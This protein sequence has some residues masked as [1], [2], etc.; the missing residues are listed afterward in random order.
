MCNLVL[1][2]P[3]IDTYETWDSNEGTSTDNV[4]WMN[5]DIDF[6]V[7]DITDYDADF[8]CFDWDD[9]ET[10]DNCYYDSNGCGGS[11]TTESCNYYAIPNSMNDNNKESCDVEGNCRE[12]T[13]VD[14]QVCDGCDFDTSDIQS[15]YVDAVV[16]YDC[17]DSQSNRHVDSLDEVHF[18]VVYP[19]KYDCDSDAGESGDD[20][21]GTGYYDFEG[22]FGT[23]WVNI[24]SDVTCPSYRVC[25]PDSSHTYHDDQEVTSRTG[26]ITH[27]CTLEDGST[28][29]HECSSDDDCYSDDCDG[30]QTVYEPTCEGSCSDGYNLNVDQYSDTC[31]G[32]GYKY[33]SADDDFTC[34]QYLGSAYVCDADL[35]GGNTNDPADFCR[36]YQD[37]SCSQSTECCGYYNGYACNDGYCS[38]CG[39]YYCN[40][41]E[42]ASDC[43]QDCCDYECSD[44]LAIEGPG[45]GSGKCFSECDGYNGCVFYNSATRNACD[46]EDKDEVVCVDEDTYVTCCE[47]TPSDCASYKYCYSGSCLTCNT[48]CNDNCQSSACYGDDPDCDSDGN[49]NGNCGDGVCCQ[50]T[51][52]SCPQDCGGVSYCNGTIEI[53]TE[54]S[55]GNPQGNLSIYI[56]S[57]Y[58]SSTDIYGDK[59]VPIKNVACGTDYNITVKCENNDIC[60][61]KIASIDESDDG[62]DLDPL[63]FDCTIC[64]GEEDIYITKDDIR[65]RSQNGQANITATVNVENVE[66]SNLKVNFTVVNKDG[67]LGD[68]QAYTI[69]SFNKYTK[70]KA[71]VLLDFSSNS[72]TVNIYVDPENDFTQDS[73]TN[74]FVSV[75]AIILETKAYLDIET[76]YPVVDDEI[77]DYLD[78]YVDSVSSDEAEVKIYVSI[79]NSNLNLPSLSGNKWRIDTLSRAVIVND[80]TGNKPY[81]GFVASFEDGS[82]NVIYV[83]GTDIEGVIASIK[84]LVDER[85]RFLV[86]S[87][88]GRDDKIYLGELDLEAIRVYDYMHNTENDATSNYNRYSTDFRNIVKNALEKQNYDT[89]IKLVRTTNADNVTLRIRHLSP[90]L[91]P[92]LR[93]AT[94][95][96]DQPVVLAHGIHSSLDSWKDFGIELAQNGRDPWLIEPYGGPGTD[97]E[98]GDNCPDYDFSDLKT[99]YWPALIAGVQTYSGKNNLSYVGYD[100]GC[101]VGLES[102]ELYPSG[103]TDIGYYL[104]SDEW[105]LTD[106]SDDPIDTFVGVA[107]IGNFSPIVVNSTFS[108]YPVFTQYLKDYQSYYQDDS[109]TF[110]QYGGH[111]PGGYYNSRGW[112][113]SFLP[114]PPIQWYYSVIGSLILSSLDVNTPSLSSSKISMGVYQDIISWINDSDNP[115]IGQNVQL[116]N[117]AIMQSSFD[118]D[119]EYGAGYGVREYRKGTDLFV[120]N[121]TQKAVCKNIVSDNKYYIGFKNFAHFGPNLPQ[122]IFIGTFP[123]SKELRNTIIYFLNNKE[124]GEGD[125]DIISTSSNCE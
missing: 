63:L 15:T 124:I 114:T 52:V 32:S 65:I 123:A 38:K 17:D 57:E 101:T 85:N 24:K 91:T 56:D 16:Y 19:K 82:D 8:V 18:W 11:C 98:C 74:N 95:D 20:K 2:V 7:N 107:C 120:S 81:N 4:I 34:S 87:N 118:M 102:L 46:G 5:D 84:R 67:S 103:Q 23:S 31:G 122:P 28:S 125:Y 77:R 80:K 49:V 86:S 113:M 64:K 69:T 93:G 27:P 106:L 45:G 100:L 89:S 88:L 48:Q 29:N 22:D 53:I 13:N 26:S 43:P 121:Q 108:I 47:G 21:S 12:G 115:K 83:I 75:P 55:E 35:D 72:M 111:L 79:L 3:S 90:Q 60:G 109:P 70:P 117:F 94:I 58:N 39:N 37:E 66:G 116:N 110:N 73:K 41:N 44:D 71:S 6:E 112:W 33:S 40:I 50:E 36:K 99:Y 97:T 42:E 59:K 54:D 119:W 1:A 25:D 62:D 10:Y 30:S 9:D 14:E 51:S 105:L 76:N 96:N 92:E 104:P 61:S 68:S 78:N